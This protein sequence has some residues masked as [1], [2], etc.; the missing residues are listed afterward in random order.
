MDIQ[1][2]DQTLDSIGQNVVV[3]DYSNK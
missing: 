2:L 1:V 3:V